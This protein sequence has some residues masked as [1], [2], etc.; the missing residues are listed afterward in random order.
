MKSLKGKLY[1]MKKES[2]R[3]WSMLGSFFPSG[4]NAE[5]NSRAPYFGGKEFETKRG[6][7]VRR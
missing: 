1:V 2:L 7:Q 6:K 5:M 4:L 3:S